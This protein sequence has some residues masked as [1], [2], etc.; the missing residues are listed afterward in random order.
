MHLE[1]IDKKLDADE[2]DYDEDTGDAEVRGH[3][4]Y[5]NF[6][7]GTKIQCDHGKYNVNSET[8]LFF[9]VTGTS[10]PRIVS[11]PGY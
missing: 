11:R 5:E 1:T 8:G 2:A 6:V 9:D 10:Q 7:D 3:V 4:R